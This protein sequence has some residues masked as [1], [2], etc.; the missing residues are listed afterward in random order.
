MRVKFKD[1]VPMVFKEATYYFT[2]VDVK[3]E[4]NVVW[5]VQKAKLD[6]SRGVYHYIHQ[7]LEMVLPGSLMFKD[8]NLHAGR[9]VK[10]SQDEVKALKKGQFGVLLAMVHGLHV[11]DQEDAALLAQLGVRIEGVETA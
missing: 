4:F 7:K 11:S 3:A 9:R 8:V 2:C 10:L 5:R 1:P 6:T